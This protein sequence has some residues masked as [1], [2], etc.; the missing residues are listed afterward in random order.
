MSLEEAYQLLDDIER[1]YRAMV[2]DLNRLKRREVMASDIETLPLIQ[3]I[4][5]GKRDLA[6]A[7]GIQKGTP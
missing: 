3:R 7:L 2:R 4:A 1:D 5:K 6:I